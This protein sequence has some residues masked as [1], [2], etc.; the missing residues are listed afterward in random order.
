VND[1]NC[2]IRSAAFEDPNQTH[3]FSW[4]TESNHPNNIQDNVMNAIANPDWMIFA[5]KGNTQSDSESAKW[6]T[7]GGTASVENSHNLFH[8]RVGGATAGGLQGSEKQF[9]F[10]DGITTPER[11][12][13]GNDDDD[14]HFDEDF[15]NMQ[16]VGTMTGNQ[17]TFDPIFWLHHG[18]VERWLLSWQH[19]HMETLGVTLP[20]DILKSTVIYPWTK[21]EKLYEGQES[22]NSPCDDEHNATFGDWWEYSSL[23][24]EYDELIVPPIMEHVTTASKATFFASGGLSLKVAQ[25]RAIDTEPVRLVVEFKAYHYKNSDFDLLRNDKLVG[26]N[27]VISGQGN[28]CARCNTNAIKNRTLHY[29]VSRGVGD[30]DAVEAAILSKA[31]T[32]KR[33]GKTIPLDGLKALPWYEG[34]NVLGRKPRKLTKT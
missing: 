20:N 26:S 24:Y 8:N 22:W 27:S 28:P 3:S 34:V 9:F 12:K 7:G 2:T 17:S 6:G 18:N 31:F 11:I 10:F 14:E 33:N 30:F 4:P 19:L 13:R 29:E 1:A 21:P 25:F 16:Y 15:K 32:L 5:T 23:H